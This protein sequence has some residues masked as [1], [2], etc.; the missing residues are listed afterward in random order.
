[1]SYRDWP[2][3]DIWLTTPDLELR[4]LSEADLGSLAA[5]FEED[6]E[7]DPSWTTYDDL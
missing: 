2:M 6:A 5:I 1:V 3:C 4:H 7:L